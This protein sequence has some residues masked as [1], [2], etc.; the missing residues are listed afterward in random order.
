MRSRVTTVVI[1]HLVCLC[2]FAVHLGAQMP[3]CCTCDIYIQKRNEAGL[4]EFVCEQ[5]SRYDTVDVG[6]EPVK[7]VFFDDDE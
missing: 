1:E 4:F 6:L 2:G 7:A 5:Y 3:V